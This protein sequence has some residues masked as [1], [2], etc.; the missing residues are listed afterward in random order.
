MKKIL[1]GLC[2]LL[3]PVVAHAQLAVRAQDR[4]VAGTLDLTSTSSALV[5]PLDGITG[6]SV[7]ANGG[8]GGS[9]I[10]EVSNDGTNWTSTVCNVHSSS[11]FPLA[12]PSAS[13]SNT[14]NAQAICDS[15]N[16][17]NFRIRVNST[18]TGSCSVIISGKA[19]GGR[20]VQIQS[21]NPGSGAAQ[22][23]KAEDAAS[24][25]GDVGVV[26]YSVRED[27]LASTTSASGDY[28][29]LKSNSLGAVYVQVHSDGAN[30]GA[31]ENKISAATNNSTSV[32]A[33]AT[34]VF[35]GSLCNT[36]GVVKYVKFYNK[37]SA[38]TCGT[39]TPF[40]RFLVPAGQCTP[41]EFPGPGAQF[42][43]GFGY[44]MVT[45]LTDADNTAVAAGDIFLQVSYK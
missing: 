17:P 15:L 22:L 14:A 30:G 3:F 2:A 39:D 8:T 45:G 32:K 26:A 27:T 36:S 34:T 12:T 6:I 16:A 1:L 23:G 10:A 35:G 5:L 19:A 28:A 9:L 7:F 43:A 41:F 18:G 44:C 21:M 42:S 33:S 38:P 11:G 31:L 4:I 24:A 40:M 20:F 13:W 29:N 37:A 25:N